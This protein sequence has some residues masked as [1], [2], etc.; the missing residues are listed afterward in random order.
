MIRTLFILLVCMLIFSGVCAA[1]EVPFASFERAVREEKG[2]FAGDKSKLSKVFQ[3]ERNRLGKDFESEL[4]KYLGDDADKH[5]WI[6]A[7]LTSTSYLHGNPAMPELAFQ[8]RTRNLKLLEGRTD[9]RSRGRAV[10][11]NRHLAISAKLEGKQTDAMM[12]RDKAEAIL[13]K[14]RDG[15]WAYVSGQ[16]DFS[17]CVY[18]NIEGSI[19]MCD[20]NPPPKERIVSA[21]WMNSRALNFADPAYPAGVPKSKAGR[22]D[23]RIVTDVEGAVI[24]AEIIRGPAELHKAA[25]EAAKKLRFQP[26][27]LSDIP[28]KVSGWVSFDFRP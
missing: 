28:T 21:G 16:T 3:D 11:I 22:V 10:S 5:F 12:Y 2:G 20:P 1:Q 9:N 4:W 8:I 25:I 6:A 13:A 26:T 14:D 15:L 24:S 19:A 27:L 18:E 17:R 7:F 23:V